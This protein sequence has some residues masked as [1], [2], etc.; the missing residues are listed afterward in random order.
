[1]ASSSIAPATFGGVSRAPGGL[2][3]LTFSS[4]CPPVFQPNTR[5]IGL[6]GTT[7]VRGSFDDLFLSDDEEPQSFKAGALEQ[8]YAKGKDILS[9]PIDQKPSVKSE[10]RQKCSKPTPM[11]LL[12]RRGMVGSFQTF[13]CKC[14]SVRDRPPY[15]YTCVLDTIW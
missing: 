9:A 4:S 13:T 12:R 6:C 10:R 15:C 8:I 3:G 7:D 11:D 1:M 14:H 5:I 2:G